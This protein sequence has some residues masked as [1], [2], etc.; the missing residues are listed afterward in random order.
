MVMLRLGHLRQVTKHGVSRLTRRLH[1]FSPQMFSEERARFYT[2]ELI[3]ALEYL[4]EMCI[5]YRDL[6]PEN[7]LLDHEGHIRLTDFGHSKDDHSR[8]DRAF[9]MVGSPYYMAPEILL[10]SG[11]GNEVDWWS[12]GILVYEMIVGLPPFYQ[13]NTRKAYEMLLT[14]P[15][16][17]PDTVSPAAQQM[18]RALLNVD[19]SKRLGRGEVDRS[20][21][22]DMQALALKWNVPWLQSVRWRRLLSK[23]EEPP[24][25]PRVSGP[26]DISKFAQHFTNEMVSHMAGRAPV[27]DLG[28]NAQSE[29]AERCDVFSDFSYVAPISKKLTSLNSTVSHYQSAQLSPFDSQS[30]STLSPKTAS[31]NALLPPPLCLSA[32]EVND[33]AQLEPVPTGTLKRRLSAGEAGSLT[34][35]ATDPINRTRSAGDGDRNCRTVTSRT[36][37]DDSDMASS[38]RAILSS[39]S[40]RDSGPGEALEYTLAPTGRHLLAKLPVSVG[41]RLNRLDA[42]NKALKTLVN[43]HDAA[44]AL[45]G[46]AAVGASNLLAH[47]R[48]DMHVVFPIAFLFYALSSAASASSDFMIFRALQSCSVDS[49]TH[50]ITCDSRL[51]TC[52]GS[53]GRNA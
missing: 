39:S 5:I 49:I 48:W 40:S 30:P 51:L 7:V 33:D 19:A 46:P 38:A 27:S 21:G 36:C 24:F 3:L 43:K 42:R 34:T 12:L 47:C 13:Q 10:N 2:A 52:A 4:H 22:D 32:Q 17:F 16:S 15:I 50:G 44:D 35:Y 26:E 28:T 11:H 53:G 25:K 41:D 8:D 6:K 31:S 29:A 1:M 9:S 18:V 20:L 23:L 45:L 14:Q 37:A